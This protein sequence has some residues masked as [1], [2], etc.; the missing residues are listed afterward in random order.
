VLENHSRG[1]LA[2]AISRSKDLTAYL[3]V[4]YS[5]VS[6]HGTPEVLVTDSEALFRANQAKAIY[7]SLGITKKE[8]ERGQ[9]W[10]SYI[11]TAFSV[12]QRLAEI[13]PSGERRASRRS[14]PLTTSL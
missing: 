4:S 14:S 7:S 10:Q 13:I 5:A 1:L 3:S 6:H 9:P 12:Q 8:I 11:E 2:S